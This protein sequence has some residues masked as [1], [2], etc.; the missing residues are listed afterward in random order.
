MIV[1]D[2]LTT[3]GDTLMFWTFTI[4]AGLAMVFVKLG[5]YS[6]WMTIFSAGFKLMIVI[7]LMMLAWMIFKRRA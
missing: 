5:A 3:Q 1:F 6:V 7:F 4:F 2:V